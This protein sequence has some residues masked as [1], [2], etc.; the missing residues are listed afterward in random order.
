MTWD[1]VVLRLNTE[2]GITGYATALAARSG[3]ITQSYLHENIAPVVLGR[4]VS[5]R[6]AIWNELWTIDRHLTFFPIYLPGPVDVALWDIAA[7]AAGL[8]LYQYLGECRTSL[9]V[10]ASS[11]FMPNVDDYVKQMREYASRG[12]TAYKAH[13]P[14][15]WKKDMEVHR[16]L[17]D[18]ATRLSSSKSSGD[19]VLMT[20]P[21]A[22]YTLEEAMSGAISRSSITTGSKSRSAISN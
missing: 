4:R 15:P 6:E 9:P 8:P 12:F 13:P 17:R 16:A 5:E 3:A 20:D 2:E 22:D 19:Y 18:A 11:L 7:R 10:Y 21:V 14:G 1:V